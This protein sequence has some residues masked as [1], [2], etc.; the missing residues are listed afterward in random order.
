M[1]DRALL[2]I[3]LTTIMRSVDAENVVWALFYQD[4][5]T[6]I[7]CTSKTG[8]LTT[9]NLRGQNPGHRGGMHM[10]AL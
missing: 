7:K 5:E 3:R 9:F 1:L 4:G 6:Y 10:Y 8:D 2:Q